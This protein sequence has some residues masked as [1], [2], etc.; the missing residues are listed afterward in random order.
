VSPEFPVAPWNLYRRRLHQSGDPGTDL[1]LAVEF[2]TPGGWQ[3]GSVYRERDGGIFGTGPQH[4]RARLVLTLVVPGQAVGRGGMI[5]DVS[6]QPQSPLVREK[7][8]NLLWD[9]GFELDRG[10]MT[11]WV[12]KPKIMDI[13]TQGPRGGHRCLHI[14]SDRTYLVF[15]SIPVQAGRLYRFRVWVRGS[16]VVWPGL[17][18]LA[19]SDW[20]SMRIDTA[21]RVGWAD[22]LVA[23]I[24]LTNDWQKVEIRTPCESE[25]IVWFQ[26]LLTFAGGQIDMDDAELN[27]MDSE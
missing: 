14:E 19:P 9:G 16:G 25:R 23:E 4:M 17:H 24:K 11:Y 10:D 7:G 21:Q 3:P 8:Q 12:T 5:D 2:Q 27:S 1:R 6:V 20:D 26:P 15:P 22:P 13:S 18:K